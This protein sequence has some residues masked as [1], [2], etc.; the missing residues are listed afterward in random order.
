VD[1]NFDASNLG[2]CPG[3]RSSRIRDPF[4]VAH[5]ERRSCKRTARAQEHIAVVVEECAAYN[6]LA[7][8][9]ARGMIVPRNCISAPSAT[10]SDGLLPGSPSLVGE[11]RSA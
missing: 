11:A 1:A 7:T 5:D 10:G 6:R 2:L 3:Q 4:L 9:A 8:V